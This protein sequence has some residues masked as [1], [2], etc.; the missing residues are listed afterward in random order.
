MDLLEKLFTSRVNAFLRSSGIGRTTLGLKAVGDPNLI[1]QIESGRSPSLRTADRV[2]AFIARTE[3]DSGA[4]R[5]PPRRRRAARSW[6]RTKRTSAR[7]AAAERP[8]GPG[9]S[10]P[11]RILRLPEVI[12][13]TGLSR[14]TIYARMSQGRFPRPVSLGARAVGWIEA[15]IEAW[16]RERIAESR[17]GRARTDDAADEPPE[18]E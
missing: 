12:A 11:T 7:G 2:L 18:D 17:G 8:D 4:A 6:A 15:E 9:T 1:R 10:R 3:G 14:A 5:D 16:I 13:R